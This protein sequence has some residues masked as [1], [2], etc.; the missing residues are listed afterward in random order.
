MRGLTPSLTVGPF[1]AP[2]LCFERGPD[3]RGDGAEGIEIVLRGTLLDGEGKPVDDGLIEIWQADAR[4]GNAGFRGFGRCGTDARGM[5]AFS[6]IKP[7]RVPGPGGVKQAP[8]LSVAVFA[9]GLLERLTTRCYFGDEESNAK[10]PILSLVAPDRRET[11]IAS[12]GPQGS[13]S[14]QFDIVLR[15]A[16]ETVFFEW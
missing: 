10:D 11:L 9:R 15:G 16:G 3:M 14:Y 7:G 5:F 4:G 6:T 12:P 2:C 1:F 13:R 8:H